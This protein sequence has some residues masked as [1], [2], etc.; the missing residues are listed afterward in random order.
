MVYIPW[1]RK[2]FARYSGVSVWLCVKFTFNCVFQEVHQI[3]LGCDRHRYQGVCSR[4]IFSSA[5]QGLIVFGQNLPRFRFHEADGRKL[6]ISCQ[7]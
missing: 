6:T 2:V 7:A 3:R 5:F 4:F 1:F